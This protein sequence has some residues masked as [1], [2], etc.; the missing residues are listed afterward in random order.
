MRIYIYGEG[1]TMNKS[2]YF[3]ALAAGLCFSLSSHAFSLGGAMA[4]AAAPAG[5]TGLCKDG[6]FTSEATKK[7]ACASHKGVKTWYKAPAG[8]AAATTSAATSAAPA[9]TAAKT[10]AT[11]PAATTTAAAAGGGAGQVWVNTKTKVY[12]CQG[13]K[14]YG[15]TKS[16]TYMTEAAAKAAGDHAAGGKT[17]S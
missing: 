9:A 7:G 2:A 10:G 1:V 13:D 5:T 6:S 12:H 3:V 15:K 11:T 17:C 14:Y 16:G 8:S 4:P